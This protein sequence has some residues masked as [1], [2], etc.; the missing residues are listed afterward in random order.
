[1]SERRVFQVVRARRTT[2]DDLGDSWAEGNNLLGVR[3]AS[4]QRGNITVPDT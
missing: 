4:W 2:V 3:C 1:M